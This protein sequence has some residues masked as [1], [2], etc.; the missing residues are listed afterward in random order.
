MIWPNRVLLIKYI[1][2]NSKNFWRFTTNG[3][4][5]FIKIIFIIHFNHLFPSKSLFNRTKSFSLQSESKLNLHPQHTN[6]IIFIIFLFRNSSHTSIS[7]EYENIIWEDLYYSFLCCHIGRNMDVYYN[8]FST[9][10]WQEYIEY[11]FRIQRK[12]QKEVEIISK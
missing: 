2:F 7:P 5:K 6:K 10:A 9:L 3:Y 11:D 12:K 8:G 1:L 4:W